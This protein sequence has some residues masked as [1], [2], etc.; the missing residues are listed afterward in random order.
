M[1]KLAGVPVRGIAGVVTAEGCIVDFKTSSRS[2]SG[3]SNAHRI[4]FT[5]CAELTGC[6]QAKIVTI[7]KAATPKVIEQT[8][9]IL[10]SDREHVRQLFPVV[11]DAMRQGFAIPIRASTFRGRKYCSF[12]RACQSDYGGTVAD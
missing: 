11:A 9:P 2:P 4:Q 7:T 5:T 3:V 1:A 10:P 6:G 12:W 8:F